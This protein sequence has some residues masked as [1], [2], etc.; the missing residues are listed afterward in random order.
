M[1]SLVVREISS[2]KKIKPR[3]TFFALVLLTLF[4]AVPSAYA[5]E[6]DDADP[7]RPFN[8]KMHNFNEFF[9]RN[10][11][12]PVAIGYRKIT[13][14]PV[15]KG[16]TNFFSNLGEPVIFINDLFFNLLCTNIFFIIKFNR[17]YKLFVIG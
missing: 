14:K 7:W 1:T 15:R 13:P 3:T 10:L 12:K 17:G 16:V 2:V 8:E 11:L 9:D 6:E 4:A 5:T